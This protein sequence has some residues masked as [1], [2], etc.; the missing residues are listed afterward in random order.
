MSGE[1]VKYLLEDYRYARQ[2]NKYLDGGQR[3]IFENK[4]VFLNDTVSLVAEF[5][6]HL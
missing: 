1:I 3:I 2:L 5:L 6:D 4:C